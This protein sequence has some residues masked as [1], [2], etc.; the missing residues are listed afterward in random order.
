MINSQRLLETFLELVKINS[1]T[2]HEEVIQPILKKKFEELGL[3]VVEDRASEKSWLGANNLICTLPATSDNQDVAKIYFTSHMD[4]VVPGLNI[5][6]Q[7]NDD[8]YIY[9]DGTTILG[10]DDKAGLAAIIETIQYLNDNK[11]PH[12]QIQF[13]ITVGEESGLKGAKELD[14]SLIDAEFGYAVDASQPVGT[15]VVGAPTQMVINSTIL[16]KTAHASTP[17]EGIS[18][19][20]IAAKAISRMKLGQIDQYTTAN[21]GKF[22]GGSATNIVADEVVLEAEARSHNDQ[23][24]EQ[25][26]AHM[27]E[28][29]ESTAQEFG[30]EAKVIIEKSYPGFKLND[31]DK[32]TQ[33]AINSAKEL[34][35]TGD[36][37]IA[38]GGS[39][40][41][42]I[43]T[44]GIPTVILGVGYEHI[45]T[46]SER[47]S[48]KSLNDLATQIVKIIELVAKS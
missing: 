3:H 44:F 10:A 35:L 24:I 4:T 23:S 5:Q 37:V 1:E 34:G 30:G 41:S 32:V 48:I 38:G 47:I 40:G 21:I 36:T 22:H 19:I 2:G 16:G 14:K 17:S 31:E 8:G 15:T 29:F 46:T 26:V 7:I 28:I 20:N 12:G 33:Y 11:M 13:I 9:S 42:I 6:P 45:H 18:A 43:N 39:D 25:Q 27:K